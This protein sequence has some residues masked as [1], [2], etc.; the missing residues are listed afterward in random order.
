MGE[1]IRDRLPEPE[2]FFESEGIRLTGP[3]KWKTGRCDFHGGSDSLRVNTESGG[4]CCMSCGEKGGD[5]LG[6]RMK[7][8]G[9]EFIEAA[10]ALGAWEEAATPSLRRHKPLPFPA[11]S[12]LEVL[13]FDALHVA[14]AACNLAQG[15]TLTEE[16]RAALVAAAGRVQRI[17]E[18]VP[19]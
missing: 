15:V 14:V 6:Y 12:A 16:D 2:A 11:R 10:K 17:A 3:G 19:A 9:K 5:V 4:W 1:F 18:E 8:T 7:L 13:R